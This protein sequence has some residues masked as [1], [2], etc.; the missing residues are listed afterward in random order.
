MLRARAVCRTTAMYEPA[1]GCP[2]RQEVRRGELAP[3]CPLCR[4]GTPWRMRALCDVLPPEVPAGW[5]GTR[6]G[7]ARTAMTWLAQRTLFMARQRAWGWQRA[8][9]DLTAVASQHGYLTGDAYL[10]ASAV[11]LEGSLGERDVLLTT[12]ERIARRLT[13]GVH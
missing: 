10:E 3:P 6:A 11:R 7:P 2:V 4:E 9:H 12:L 13:L 1:C 8:V 5:G